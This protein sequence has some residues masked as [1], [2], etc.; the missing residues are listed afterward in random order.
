VPNCTCLA[1]ARGRRSRNGRS[2]RAGSNGRQSAHAAAEAPASS[3]PSASLHWSARWKRLS[4]RPDCCGS[5]LQ[6]ASGETCSRQ[7]IWGSRSRC[8]APAKQGRSWL[9]HERKAGGTPPCHQDHRAGWLSGG[10]FY[11]RDRPDFGGK[12][13]L[14]AYRRNDEAPAEMGFRLVMPGDKHGG[15]Y[16]RD[17]VSIEVE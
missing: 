17:V 5:G 8:S 1:P 11:G 15:R 3:C 9:L 10:N 13:A 4:V 7:P 2:T 12:P 14:L 6:V 16:V